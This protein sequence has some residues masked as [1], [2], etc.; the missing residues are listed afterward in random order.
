MPLSKTVVGICTSLSPPPPHPFPRVLLPDAAQMAKIVQALAD[1]DVL[2]EGTD[3]SANASRVVHDL[4]SGLRELLPL[5]PAELIQPC[6]R[7]E[8]LGTL[9]TCDKLASAQ[10]YHSYV[11]TKVL[12]MHV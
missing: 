8:G 12:C 10:L 5:H 9:Q 3:V 11:H 4:L 1:M 6:Q 7:V 2:S